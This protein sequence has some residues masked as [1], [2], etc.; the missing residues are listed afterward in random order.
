MA[1]QLSPADHTRKGAIELANSVAQSL[2]TARLHHSRNLL[3]S[4][5]GFDL[6]RI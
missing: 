2:L 1:E 5:G 4:S 3:I 6:T